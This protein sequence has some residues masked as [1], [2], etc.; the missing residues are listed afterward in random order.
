MASWVIDK[1]VGVGIVFIR[2]NDVLV[3]K[4][5]HFNFKTYDNQVEY[6]TLI[7]GLSLTR[8]ME[9]SKVI[10]AILEIFIDFKLEHILREDNMRVIILSKLA[11]TKKKG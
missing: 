10:K 8:E 4:S 6:E 5:L 1:G 9:E 11:S 3:E 7:V 2:P